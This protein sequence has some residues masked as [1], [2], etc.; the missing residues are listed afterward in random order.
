MGGCYVEGPDTPAVK[1]PEEMAGR[2][3][4]ELMTSLA[5]WKQ[6][7][8]ADP[9]CLVD[10][11]RE[12][13][14]AFARGADLLIVGLIA[15]TMKSPDFCDRAQRTRK[16]AAVPLSA[17]RQRQVRVRLLGGLILWVT[18]LYCA[19]RKRWLSARNDAAPGMY[20]ELAQ[21]GFGKGCTPGLQSRVARQAALCPSLAFAQQELKREGVELDVKTVRRIAH[22]CGEGVLQLRTQARLLWREGKLPAGG[23]LA[24]KRVSV[25]LAGGRDVS[26]ARCPGRIGR[27]A[28]AS[29][30]GGAGTQRDLCR[31][32]RGVDLG[33]D[34]GDCPAGQ[35]ERRARLPGARLL[36]RGTSRFAGVGG[37]G[38]AGR[39]A[40]AALPRVPHA[41]AK[42]PL[43]ASGRR[44]GGHGERGGARLAGLD[45]NPISAKARRGRTIEVSHVSSEWPAPGEWRD[46]K[47]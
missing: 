42:W 29:A 44:I 45:R 40:D 30:G 31:R 46:R 1:S 4:G 38:M 12:V 14:A 41:A 7:L 43:A 35:T 2:F 36:P 10:L 5:G 27:R 33:T 28:L 18:S 26:R 24:G 15:L 19:P 11:E 39:P 25:Q 20:V 34:R 9:D 21:F 32:R 17:G 23:E 22:Q 37:A 13:H 8:L 6:R 47:Q 16:N 3:Q